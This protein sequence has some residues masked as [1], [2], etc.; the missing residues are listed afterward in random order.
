[1]LVGIVDPQIMEAGLGLDLLSVGDDGLSLDMGEER[2]DGFA[3][4]SDIFLLPLFNVLR[5]DDPF[6]GGD[7]AGVDGILEVIFLP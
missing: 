4:V 2:V 7:S 1:M 6:N 5:I 3:V